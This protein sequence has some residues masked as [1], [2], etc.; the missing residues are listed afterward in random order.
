[1]PRKTDVRSPAAVFDLP[2]ACATT[3]RAARAV[4]Q[5]YDSHLRPNDIEATQFALLS[6]LESQEPCSQASIS[7]LLALDKTTLSRNLKLL[8]NKGWIEA[9]SA[10]DRRE[11]RFILSAAGKKRL[12]QAKPAWRRAQEQLRSSMTAKQWD[13]MWKAFRAVTEAA[14]KAPNATAPS[15][16]KR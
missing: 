14:Q 1:M 8:K 5:L 16:R 13:A 7:P 4:T 3:R 2:C 9:A 11:R 12:A 6:V 10:H 15:R